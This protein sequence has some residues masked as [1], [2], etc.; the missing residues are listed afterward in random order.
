MDATRR[1]VW[2]CRHHQF[3]PSRQR[4]L[5][6]PPRDWLRAGEVLELAGFPT[7]HCFSGV[8]AG[9]L[10]GPN[11]Y[12]RLPTVMRRSMCSECLPRRAEGPWVSIGSLSWRPC[13]LK[14]A[15]GD[16]PVLGC[17]VSSR[18]RRRHA[19]G[20]SPGAYVGSVLRLKA[21]VRGSSPMTPALL[22]ADLV[23]LPGPIFVDVSS[24]RDEVHSGHKWSIRR[25][26]K[27]FDL[28]R[29]V[30]PPFRSFIFGERSYRRR[31]A[32]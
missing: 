3:H 1:P 20:V 4:C 32:K 24:T 9:C 13:L 23:V 15:P 30:G 31:S 29:A 28:T 12:T 22:T 6:L 21:G 10:P 11:A 8:G 26:H 27:R 18:R 7:E 17:G 19:R 2:L 14:H 16:R 25:G 5:P